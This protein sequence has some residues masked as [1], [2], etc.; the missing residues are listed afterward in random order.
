L[1]ALYKLGIIRPAVKICI[2]NV[3]IYY[4]KLVFLVTNRR[5]SGHGF[6]KLA[7][8]TYLIVTALQISDEIQSVH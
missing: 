8:D 5:K 4:I 7:A 1:L 6:I 3:I 2:Y